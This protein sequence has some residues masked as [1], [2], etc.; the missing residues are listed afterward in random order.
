MTRPLVISDCDE[1]LLH[2]V[3]PFGEWLEEAHGITSRELADALKA[4]VAHAAKT[5]DLE[6]QLADGAEGVADGRVTEYP[7]SSGAQFPFWSPD[8]RWIAF[9]SRVDGD[10]MKRPFRRGLFSRVGLVAGTALPPA[11]VTP[12]GLRERG[13]TASAGSRRATGG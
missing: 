5:K 7:G 1:V 8:G 10:A 11:Q 2:M 13:R 12:A 6:Q 3:G 9:F 4:T